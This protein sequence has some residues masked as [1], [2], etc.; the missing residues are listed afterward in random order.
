MREATDILISGGGVAGLTAAGAFGTR[1]LPRHL[2]RP[3]TPGHRRQR[4][5][6]RPAHHRVPAALDPRPAGR[7]ASGP[8]L[9]P[10]PRP[11]RSCGSSTPGGGR[12]R[13]ASPRISTLPTSP[14]RPSAGTCPTGFSAAKWSPAWP[15]CRTSASAPAPALPACSTRD[16]E[17]LVTLTDGT[18]VSARL[19]IGADGRNS[20]V[21]E[22]LGIAGEN[23]PLRPEGAR[24]RRDATR[25]P[26]PERLDRGP[27]H[28]RPL[29][30][31]PPPRPRRPPSLGRRLDGNRRRGRPP[32]RPPRRR[33][34]S[35][36]DRPLLPVSSA[37]SR[38]SPADRSGR[39]SA[40]SPSASP[41]PAACFWP[42]PPMSSRPSARRG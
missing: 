25:H 33:V 9:N 42:K 6:R 34:R 36:D 26:A 30:P 20:P 5:R 17:A 4:K 28:R 41:A 37:P 13:P 8:A 10:T 12:P 40:S 1:G 19:V 31:R 15:S 23:H 22:A 38:L 24:L 18:Q 2:R 14:T 27:P 39:S 16:A 35:R 32:R 7:A 11:C 29:H 21:R 3:A